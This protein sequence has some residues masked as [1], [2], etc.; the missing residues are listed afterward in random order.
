MPRNF[1][2][3]GFPDSLYRP[4]LGR[5]GK[6]LFDLQKANRA[7]LLKLGVPSKNIF[8]VDICTHCDSRFLSY[9]RDKGRAGRML[10]FIGMSE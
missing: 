7:Q 6:Y 4:I 10:S 2:A 5:P 1:A 9:R 8:A 3:R